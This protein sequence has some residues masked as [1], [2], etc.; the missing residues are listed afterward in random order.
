M[1][2]AILS[3]T[4]I[5]TVLFPSS[6]LWPLST[7]PKSLSLAVYQVV[8]NSK[9]SMKRIGH[10]RGWARLPVYLL[11][12]HAM[13]VGRGMLVYIRA[14][15]NTGTRCKWV[16]RFTHGLLYRTGKLPSSHGTGGWV[17]L[18]VC[19]VALAKRKTSRLCRES[20]TI[21]RLSNP[22]SL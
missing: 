14:L 8:I 4:S 9:M 7:S 13:S 16:A 2:D 19:R 10:S 21:P 3:F 17:G 18:I 20:N 6:L 22:V 11:K 5:S 12:Q 15:L 1:N